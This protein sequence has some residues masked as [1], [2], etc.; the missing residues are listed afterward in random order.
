M[1]LGLFLLKIHY[2]GK[3][4]ILERN[5]KTMLIDV[6]KGTV[7]HIA[8]AIGYAI[9]SQMRVTSLIIRTFLLK[10]PPQYINFAYF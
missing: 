8:V 10:C 9:N 2:S 1:K 3:K 4:E 6:G 5:L 7:Y